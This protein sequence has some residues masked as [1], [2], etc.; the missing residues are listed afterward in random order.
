M[1]QAYR[2]QA[3]PHTFTTRHGS[4]GHSFLLILDHD[5]LSLRIDCTSKMGRFIR[6]EIIWSV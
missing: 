2:R 5:A 1:P 3:G 4:E 6:L